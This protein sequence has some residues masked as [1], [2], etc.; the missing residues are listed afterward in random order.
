MLQ[1]S[2]VIA[3]CAEPE[4]AEAFLPRTNVGNETGQHNSER[5]ACADGG[6]DL[7][8]RAGVFLGQLARDCS[9]RVFIGRNCIAH[10]DSLRL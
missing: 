9:R 4:S 7:R 1:S 5:K 10:L 8:F 3:V 2:S 6:A